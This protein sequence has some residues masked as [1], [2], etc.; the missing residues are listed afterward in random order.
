MFSLA[1]F[2]FLAFAFVPALCTPGEYLVTMEKK[3]LIDAID[4]VS[5][6]KNPLLCTQFAACEKLMSPRVLFALEE[7]K[8]EI[9]PEG[10]K[11]CNPRTVIFESKE[12]PEKVIVT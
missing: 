5:K 4:C 8:I 9:V 6:S 2:G 7:C 12:V 11:R 10:I 1:A 3:E